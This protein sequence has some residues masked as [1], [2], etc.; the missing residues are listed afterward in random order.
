M[1]RHKSAAENEKE[2]LKWISYG[3]DILSS[4][5]TA[6]VMNQIEE[7]QR[8][9]PEKKI[10]VFSQF[11]TFH[12]LRIREKTT[13]MMRMLVLAEMFKKRGWSYLKYT[14][15]M[16]QAHRVKALEDFTNEAECKILIASLKAGG[17]GLNLTMASKVICVDLWWNSSV[18]QQGSLSISPST[19][20]PRKG[21]SANTREAFCRVFRIGQ[22]S[23][24]FISR[25][26]VRNTVDERIQAMQERKQKAIGQ[27]IDDDTMLREMTLQELMGLFGEVQLDENEKPFILVDDEGEYDNE[28]PPTMLG[29]QHDC[30]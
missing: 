12:G 25:F 24:T 9:E 28:G 17:V 30:A 26:V 14:G 3:G 22:E 13:H 19:E 6:A 16:S 29:S 7:W 11:H 5:K 23:E 2:N 1:S 18:E 10:I 8:D 21:A 27:A 4:T 15:R 20:N